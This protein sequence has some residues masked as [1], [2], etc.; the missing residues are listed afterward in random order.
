MNPNKKIA[1]IIVLVVL[2]GFLASKVFSKLGIFGGSGVKSKQNAGIPVNTDENN[3]K[4]VAINGT[5]VDSTQIRRPFAVVV[6]NHVDSRP[7]SGLSQADIVYEAL[8]EGGI[9][10]FLA[11]FQTE[12]V[13]MIG[14]VRSARTYFNDWAQE[15]HAI[16]AHVGGNSD[17]LYYIKKGIPGV[18]DADQFFNGQYFERI[19]PR[20]PPHNTY[21]STKQLLDLAA[22]HKFSLDPEF[23]GYLF[24]DEQA[25]STAQKITIGFSEKQYEVQ[26]VYDPATNLYKRYIAGKKAVDAGNDKDITA[27][28]VIVQRVAN[29]PVETDTPFSISMGTRDGGKA[30]IFLD[31]KD[32]QATWKLVNGRTK[33]FDNSGQELH[34][35]RGAIW[36]EIVP[37]ENSVTVQDVVDNS[38]KDKDK[39]E[40]K[41]K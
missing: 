4:S 6:E 32:I 13:K 12:D 37:P 23:D 33:F 26:W 39:A 5:L 20:Y 15:L 40:N 36:L 38:V 29:W 14:P 21:T 10:R 16:Y 7:Q 31:G 9:T 22:E 3:G 27:K 8:A 11:V 34:L 17:A 30:E 25:G 24:K 35:N 41:N 19:K 18:S 1:L 2:T 28:N